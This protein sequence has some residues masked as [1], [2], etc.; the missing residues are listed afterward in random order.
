MESQGSSVQYLMVKTVLKIVAP[1]RGIIAFTSM[2]T[3]KAG[4]SVPAPGHRTFLIAREVRPDQPL[5]ILSL[6]Y[7]SRELR[8]S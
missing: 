4:R 2:P 6:G 7:R 8:M 5:P 1:I 3:D